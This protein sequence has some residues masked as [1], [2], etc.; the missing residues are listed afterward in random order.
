MPA[1]GQRPPK[2]GRTQAFNGIS[3]F[4][5]RQQIGA[6]QGFFMQRQPGKG[7][8]ITPA[9]P[10][11]PFAIPNLGIIGGYQY[12]R[13]AF[14]LGIE[15]KSL[16]KSHYDPFWGGYQYADPVGYFSLGYNY[17]IFRKSPRFKLKPGIHT[18]IAIL[19]P[20]KFDPLYVAPSGGLNLLF[21][22]HL[23]SH[24][25]LSQDIRYTMSYVP[26]SQEMYLMGLDFNFG[27]KFKLYTPSQYKQ[28]LTRLPGK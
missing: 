12:K 22:I 26:L 15:L 3:H 7:I 24:F 28:G 11:F 19:V 2:S 20:D 4:Y 6:V 10:F 16:F 14:E 5:I 23:G 18:G 21:E 9:L 8:R 17:D 27:L 25:V 13:H 1:L